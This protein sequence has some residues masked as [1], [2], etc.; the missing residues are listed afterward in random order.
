AANPREVEVALVACGAQI[1]RQPLGA[2]LVRTRETDLEQLVHRAAH[3]MN[4]EHV[5]PAQHV[6]VLVL[7]A[8]ALTIRIATFPLCG[9]KHSPSEQV[10]VAE[11]NRA[12]RGTL[13]APA[14]YEWYVIT[15]FNQDAHATR[16]VRHGRYGCI[17][18]VRL[19]AQQSLGLGAKELA[20]LL[21]FVEQK[22]WHYRA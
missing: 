18:N 11:Q 21:A 13:Q 17:G 9:G 6:V 1:P 12:W 16:R 5:R 8:K 10:A 15:R 2:R 4:A 14:D 22:K 3:G 7:Y 20:A 19:R